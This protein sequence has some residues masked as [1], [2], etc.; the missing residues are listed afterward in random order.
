[1][2]VHFSTSIL[3]RFAK[4]VP[5]LKSATD[6]GGFRHFTAGQPEFAEAQP[7]RHATLATGTF[8]TSTDTFTGTDNLPRGDIHFALA[9]PGGILF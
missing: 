9:S 3:R 8:V 1:L 4:G 2:S 6:A 5:P 7:R